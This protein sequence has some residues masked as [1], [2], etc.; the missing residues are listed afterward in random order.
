MARRHSKRRSSLKKSMDLNM[1]GGN[2][3]NSSDHAIS[4]YGDIGN[5]MSVEQAGAGKG[6]EIFS[7]N[8]K[9]GNIQAYQSPNQ[10]LNYSAVAG[11]KKRKTKI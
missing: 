10:N 3:A 5:Q 2:I 7:S 4:V 8:M 6:N 1:L 11:G 9:G